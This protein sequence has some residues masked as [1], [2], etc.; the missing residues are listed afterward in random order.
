M[1]IS[2]QEKLKNLDS[3]KA[4]LMLLIVLLHSMRYYGGG[5][6]PSEPKASAP[7]FGCAAEWIGSFAMATFTLIS[8]YL[9]C[10]IKH[11][12][13][14]YK[15]YFSLIANKAKRLLV[16]YAFVSVLYVIPVHIYFF[17][18]DNIVSDFVLGENPEYLWFLLMLFGVFALFAPLANFIYK[19]PFFGGVVVC[20]FFC[21]S[22][23]LPNYYQIATALRYSMFFYIGFILYRYDRLSILL[24]KIPILLYITVDLILYV[25]TILINGNGMAFKLFDIGLGFLLNIFGA[26]AAFVILQKVVA[27]YL[28]NNRILTFFAKH[29]MTIYLIHQPIIF[30][31]IK[32]LNGVVSPII[33]VATSFILSLGLSTV[34]SLLLFK[35]K[36][37]RF[38]I[39]CK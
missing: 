26:V 25:M 35:T 21:A 36:I 32:L 39:G 14:G 28:S 17:S 3:V 9:F 23:V 24:D 22:M 29:S 27:K 12:K 11:E 15:K 10:Y 5:W 20:V 7:I 33:V 2:K 13:C 34:F 31:T 8:G 30:F 1:T 38:L 16:P 4:I 37:I 19:H 6:G 18:T